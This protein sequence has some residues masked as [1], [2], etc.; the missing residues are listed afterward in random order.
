MR[1]VVGAVI[2]S[3]DDEF[4][5]LVEGFIKEHKEMF[6]YIPINEYGDCL[7]T[8]QRENILRADKNVISWFE[9][10]NG[11]N[12]YVIVELPEGATDFKVY[13]EVYDVEND[14]SFEAIDYVIDGKIHTMSN[15]SIRLWSQF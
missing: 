14:I 4:R 7:I 3:L 5:R 9:E 8:K 13:E 10:R 11:F 1:V 6:P 12:Q 2:C 15:L